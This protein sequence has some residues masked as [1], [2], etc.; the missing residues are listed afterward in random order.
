MA[1]SSKQLLLVMVGEIR[2]DY[3]SQHLF[4]HGAPGLIGDAMPKKTHDTD[5]QVF[6]VVEP[7]ATPT[8]V[9]QKAPGS[10]RLV[11]LG[12]FNA[13]H[14]EWLYPYSD[15]DHAGREIYKFAISCGLSQLVHEPT[16]IPD[17]V[18]H[19][20]Y[21][22]DLLLTTD[23]DRYSIYVSPPLGTSDHCV[24][25]S[26]SH[27]SPPDTSPKGTRRVWRY[28][29]ADW[30][31]MRH[32]FASYPWRQVCFSSR[33]PSCCADSVSSVIYQC[34]EYF[35]PFAEVSLETKARTWFNAECLLTEKRK[36]EAYLSWADARKNKALDVQAKKKT[37]NAATK[38]CKKAIRKARFDHN[39]RIGGKLASFPSGSKAFWSLAKSVEKNF[40][41]S[42]LPPLHKPDGSL[43]HN[44]K[45][46]ANLFANLFA[47]YSRLDINGKCPPQLPPLGPKMSAVKIHQKEVLKYLLNLD[48]NKVS[49]PDGISAVVLECCTPD[50]LLF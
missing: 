14:K 12:D 10:N 21:C 37:Y 4:L 2:L 27:Y 25:K 17:V 11:F 22:L 41:H 15:T 6:K 3:R 36:H 13:H 8:P 32:F 31:E 23:P 46:K 30:D 29:S 49:G 9:A 1:S 20:A 18:G 24:V 5:L 42:S 16:R 50:C 43:A 38:S 39:G 48:V 28:K 35:I 40:C 34:M 7:Q 19:T 45:E 33:D 44:A 47:E 26:V